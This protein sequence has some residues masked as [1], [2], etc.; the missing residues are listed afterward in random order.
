MYQ[1]GDLAA[2]EALQELQIER[3]FAR[4]GRPLLRIG[5]PHDSVNSFTLVAMEGEQMVA[6]ATARHA[7]E[8]VL[9][10]DGGWGTPHE[11]WGL[12]QTL[13]ERGG[14]QCRA[15]GL[16]E[17]HCPT[18]DWR[19]ARRLLGLQGAYG[20]ARPHVIFN[21]TERTPGATRE[22]TPDCRSSVPL[23]VGE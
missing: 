21:L 12:I 18:T 11:R 2:F 16:K 14:E 15:L 22:G 17:L 1:P 4:T 8:A 13:L 9:L 6:A 10:T 19:F 20:D 3:H 7:V 23:D 5:H